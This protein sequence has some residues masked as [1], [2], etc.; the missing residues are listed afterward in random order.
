MGE[1]VWEIIEQ[2]FEVLDQ[3]GHDWTYSGHPLAAGLSNLD[4]LE[5]ESLTEN[6]ATPARI[7]RSN[8]TPRLIFIRS[9]G[10]CV[11]WV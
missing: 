11:G 1:R 3:M 7:S 8:F 6:A 9:W 10:K 5:V 2:G 4:I